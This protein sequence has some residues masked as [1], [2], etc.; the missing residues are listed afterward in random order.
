MS[1][2]AT[3]TVRLPNETRERLDKLSEVTART[4]SWLTVRALDQYLET[5][6][7]QIEAIEAGVRAADR[8]E[9]ASDAEAAAY[10]KRH[11]SR[12]DQTRSS[13]SPPDRSVRRRG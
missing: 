5:Q 10:F 9:F 1:N 11:E 7:W 4:R 2:G 13:R 6:L 8:G 12:V 3:L